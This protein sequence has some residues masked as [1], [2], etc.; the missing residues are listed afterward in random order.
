[1]TR[2]ALLLDRDGVI[3]RDDGF[4]HRWADVAFLPG[5]FELGRAA[6]GAGAAI[7]VVTNQSGIARGYFTRQDVERLHERMADRFEA[8]GCPRPQFLLC[9]HHPDFSG[10]C[11]C[12]K[13]ARLLAERGLALADAAPARSLMIGDQP[14]D[15]QPAQA[16]GILAVG[17]G[18]AAA[19]AADVAIASLH[20]AL[21][22]AWG[23]WTGAERF[24]KQRER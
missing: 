23:R 12:R 1:M 18:P 11:L 22:V 13:P 10:R 15:L 2:P 4:V 5:L 8:E 14:R 16:L 7:I 20:A 21:P 6:T 24:Q 19:A 3:H 9:P 17:L